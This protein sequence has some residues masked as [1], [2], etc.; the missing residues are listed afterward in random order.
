MA[1]DDD[2][3]RQERPKI[4]PEEIGQDSTR[5]AI[6][7][8]DVMAVRKQAGLDVPDEFK[9][10]V[11]RAQRP[12]PEA[13]NVQFRPRDGVQV[14]GNIPPA[15]RQALEQR[16]AEVESGNVSDVPTQQ[17]SDAD[18]AYAAAQARE[19]QKEATRPQQSTAGVETSMSP[20]MQPQ[21]PPTPTVGHVTTNDPAL[22][23]LLQGLQTQIYEPVS[24]P[25]KGHF[26][27]PEDADLPK[28]G[29]LHLRPMTGQD[30]SILTTVRFMRHGR[31]IEMIF[32]N[33]LRENQVNTEKLLSVDR[34]YLL[35]YLRAISFGNLYDVRVTCPD[36][37][38]SFDNE[39]DLNLPLKYCAD[40]FTTESLTMTLPES[41]YKFHYRLMTGEDEQKI[42]EHREKVAKA[43]SNTIDDTAIF[44]CSLL[45]EWIGN[46]KTTITD[47]TAIRTLLLQ[48]PAR[49]TNFLRNHVGETPFGPETEVKMLCP[50]CFHEFEMELPY[51]VNFFFPQ[52][53]ESSML[54]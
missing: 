16:I 29:M 21:L 6:T 39:I 32:R 36:C 24:L 26:Y 25:S 38:H 37:S 30:E 54:V 20:K 10:P 42:S 28:N 48:L 2:T 53:K 34:T 13:E 27:N 46:D 22:N 41:G 3:F 9:D 14:G 11:E 1:K 8:D 43:G 31:G 47:K 23:E 7:P 17:M 12:V 18:S 19:H 5:P 40:D 4:Q 49:D 33:C 50:S 51:D 35:I 15:M 52:E 45:I 44:R